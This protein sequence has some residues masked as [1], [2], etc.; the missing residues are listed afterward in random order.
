MGRQGNAAVWGSLVTLVVLTLPAFGQ[1]VPPPA[2]PPFTFTPPRLDD[3]DEWAPDPDDPLAPPP[4]LS[5]QFDY[6]AMPGG[7]G[8]HALALQEMELTTTAALPFFMAPMRISPRFA[9]RAFGGPQTRLDT[10]LAD[11]PP[12]VYD[13]MLEFNW[14]PRL[15]E[16]LFLDLAIAPGIYSDFHEVNQSSYKWQGRALS[17]VAFSEKFQLVGGALYT[18]RNTTKLLPAG[19]FL[20]SP[21][22]DT[23]FEIVFPQPK[24]AYRIYHSSSLQLWTY[25]ANEFG[26]GAWTIQRADGVGHSVDY[27]DWRLLL[28]LEWKTSERLKGRVEVGYVHK[29]MLD[30]TSTTPDFKADPTVLLRAGVSY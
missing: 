18:N 15:K 30:Y 28:G 2:P 17:I 26:G 27:R 8:R 21:N 14:R 10:G 29:R 12:E 3:P 5:A 25:V 16:W 20:W 23:C 1:E 22:P 9:A 11:L 24:V 13:L 7:N 6:T 4:P 19:G